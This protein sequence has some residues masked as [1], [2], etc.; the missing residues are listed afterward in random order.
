VS[1]EPGADSEHV[2]APYLRF[3]LILIGVIAA[4]ILVST[5]SGLIAAPLLSDLWWGFAIGLILGVPGVLLF[6]YGFLNKYTSV[7]ISRDAAVIGSWVEVLLRRQR[8]IARHQ[9]REVILIPPVRVQ[10][11]LDSGPFTVDTTSWRS[12][13]YDALESACARFDLPWRRS[14]PQWEPWGST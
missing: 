1:N 3:E 7:A 10:F 4:A 6:T 14:S 12:R 5:V 13:D 9:V 11:V 8:A 2:F